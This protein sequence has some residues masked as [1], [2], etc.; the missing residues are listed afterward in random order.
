MLAELLPIYRISVHFTWRPKHFSHVNLTGDVFPNA[1]LRRMAPKIARINALRVARNAIS[2]P[3]GELTPPGGSLPFRNGMNRRNRLAWV[4]RRLWL[5]WALRRMMADV[6]NPKRIRWQGVLLHRLASVEFG[7]GGNRDIGSW[8]IWP[9]T[10]SGGFC[11]RFFGWRN[12]YDQLFSE[13]RRG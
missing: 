3:S 11:M 8:A 4:E 9:I 2:Q 6:R 12:V 1:A 5:T 13:C 10:G 7:L